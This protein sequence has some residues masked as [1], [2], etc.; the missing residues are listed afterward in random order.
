MQGDHWPKSVA[1]R[2]ITG[3]IKLKIAA[4]TEG[5]QFSFLSEHSRILSLN[6]RPQLLDLRH[7]LGNKRGHCHHV[8]LKRCVFVCLRNTLVRTTFNNGI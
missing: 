8:A 3:E 2:P 1:K 6:L 4:I 7:E 5:I